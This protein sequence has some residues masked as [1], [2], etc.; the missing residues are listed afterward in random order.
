LT[1]YG[2]LFSCLLIA[3]ISTGRPAIAADARL[4]SDNLTYHGTPQRT[5][6]YDNERMLTPAAVQVHVLGL[7]GDEVE[8]VAHW[9]E[10]RDSTLTPP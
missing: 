6:W 1:P 2:R 8:T 4:S 7:D 10:A 3:L 5:G 9:L